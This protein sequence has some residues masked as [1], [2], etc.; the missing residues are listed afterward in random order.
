M[1]PTARV[2]SVDDEPRFLDLL[3][4]VVRAT[5]HLELVG[6]AGSGE[7]GVELAQALDPDIVMLDVR[8]PGLDGIE[9]AKKIKLA[10]PSALVVLISTTHPSELSAESRGVAD[11]VLWKSDLEPQ[12]LDELWMHSRNQRGT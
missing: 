8:M 1:R 12:M 3:G 2:L 10:R 5:N 9:A 6:E 7:L 11:A 4:G